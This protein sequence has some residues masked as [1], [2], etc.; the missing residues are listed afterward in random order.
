[1]VE[2]KQKENSLV[3]QWHPAFSA[4]LQIELAQE[5]KYLEFEEEH[6][7]S[8]KPMQMDLLIIKK[9][10]G[11]RIQK[12]IGRVFRTYNVV[13]Y[14]SPED[15]L[16]IDDFYKVYGYACFYKADTGRT[17]EV[18][19][20]EISIS[21]VCRHYPRKLMEY[22]ARQGREIVQAEPGIYY[23]SDTLFAIQVIVQKELSA[24]ENIWLHS[25]TNDL[26]KTRET[27][28]LLDLYG[29]HE[30]N[31]L[32]QSVMNVIVRANEKVFGGDDMCEALWEI[33]QPYIDKRIAEMAEERA[34]GIAEERA[35]AM[36]EERAKVIAEERAKAM[37]EERA[38]VMA[39]ERAKAMAEE[40]AK[41]MAE[42]RAK[43]MAEEWKKK[44]AEEKA[45]E[46]SISTRTEIVEKLV[47]SKMLE[48]E[49][50]CEVIGITVD[51]YEAGKCRLIN[52]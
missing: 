23:I 35:K 22:W 29:K 6:L 47:A 17:D 14:K 51:E 42:E 13:E 37:A 28:E 44:I 40:R 8:A 7:L 45:V 31:N 52:A 10:E 43:A 4:G 2:Q 41:A 27:D 11:Y 25:L 46:S 34:K 50:I 32:Y 36:A 49:K 20:E 9:D 39:E 26:E 12:N 3:I 24:K 38:K 48:L 30:K 33:W 16:S 1:M 5:E 21:F 18:K 15:Y 19:T